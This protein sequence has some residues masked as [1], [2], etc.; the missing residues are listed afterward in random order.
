VRGETVSVIGPECIPAES[1]YASRVPLDEDLLHIAAVA[2]DYAED[3]EELS[4]LLAAEPDDGRRV[5][6]AAY[7]SDDERSWL[8]LDS[9]GGPV[10]ARSVVRESVSILGMCELAEETAGGGDLDQLRSRLAEIKDTETPVGIED[11]DEAAARL[12][13]VIGEPPQVA[14]PARLDEVGH[15][16]R[17]LEVALGEGGS[18]FAEAMKA[19]MG[20]VEALTEEVEANYKLALT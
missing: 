1:A 13:Q 12:Q 5:Y 16:T 3:G 20:S 8:A 10:Q 19:G 18:P 9:K 14:S 2:A 11:A 15:A 6:L 17:C 4:G 7:D